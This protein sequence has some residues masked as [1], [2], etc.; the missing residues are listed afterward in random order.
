MN[1]SLKNNL[2]HAITLGCLCSIA[3][4][5]AYLAKE[6]L[7]LFT[8]FHFVLPTFFIVSLLSFVVEMRQN[9]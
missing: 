6:Q 5:C 7:S 1:K 9:K 4:L 2:E 8:F 3:S